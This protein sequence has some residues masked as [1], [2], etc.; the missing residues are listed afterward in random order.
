M[1]VASISSTE[2]RDDD[3]IPAAGVTRQHSGWRR[4]MSEA[5]SADDGEPYEI[6]NTPRG[7]AKG[8]FL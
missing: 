2:A 1:G 7:G 8:A 5:S 4:H 6:R 3:N